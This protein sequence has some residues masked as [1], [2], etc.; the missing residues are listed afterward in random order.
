MATGCQCTLDL[1]V[2]AV[3]AGGCHMALRM[4]ALR[5]D[6]PTGKVLLNQVHHIHGSLGQDSAWTKDGRH[7]SLIQHLIVLRGNYPTT[8]HDDVT[9]L[10]KVPYIRVRQPD[11]P[12]P[13]LPSLHILQLLDDLRHQYAMA[14]SQRAHTHHMHIC[15]HRL[16]GHLR[17]CLQGRGSITQPHPPEPVAALTLKR[18]P[19]STSKPMSVKPVAMILYPLS[20]P[21]SPT[22]ATRRRGRR[23]SRPSKACRPQPRHDPCQRQ[24]LLHCCRSRHTY[25]AP[26]NGPLH[27]LAGPIRLSICST[28]HANRGNMAA[29]HLLQCIRDLPYC[30]PSSG[31]SHRQFQEVATVP[32]PSCALSEGIQQPANSFLVPCGPHLLQLAPLGCN[33]RAVVNGEHFHRLLLLQP[34]LVHT[35]N[36]LCRTYTGSEPH[37]SGSPTPPTLARVYAALPFGRCLFNSQLGHARR[38]RLCHPPK[39]LHLKGAQFTSHHRRE[40]GLEVACTSSMISKA[41]LQTSSVRDSIR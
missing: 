18:G 37:P 21:S 39:A 41:L 2:C 32:R 33:H 13:G 10:R 35:H 23:P 17:R 22:L 27:V 5:W 15:V 8:H 3:G 40:G 34:V 20:W 6:W 28:H 24:P 26:R 19:M 30:A 38:N 31:S 11:D 16:L 9:A 7:S 25:L 1:S 12:P 4:P 14:G 29:K 36:G